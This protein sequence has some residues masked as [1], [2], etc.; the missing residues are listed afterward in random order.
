MKKVY[1]T[2]QVAKV[3]NVAAR[4]VSKWTDSGKLLAYRIPGSQDRRIPHEALV[5]FMKENRIPLNFLGN[6]AN[7]GFL[8]VG[9]PDADKM[10]LRVLLSPDI[11]IRCLFADRLFDA[12]TVFTSTRPVVVIVD[13]SIGR[14]DAHYICKEFSAKSIVM[15]V[16]GEDESEPAVTADSVSAIRW[17][18]KPYDVSALVESLREFVSFGQLSVNV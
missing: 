12:G 15:V 16:F 7:I 8:F 3:L 1:T 4:T 14:T 9:F 5:A 11:P 6:D 18:K 2:G 13:F 17:F 10:K